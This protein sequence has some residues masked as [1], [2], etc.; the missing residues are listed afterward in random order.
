MT[1]IDFVN[2][3]YKFGA[4][5]LDTLYTLSKKETC[6]LCMWACCSDLDVSSMQLDL[7]DIARIEDAKEEAA[8]AKLY[9]DRFESL[10]WVTE[11]VL[12]NF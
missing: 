4:Y 1:S 11:Q 6:T 3:V 8:S 5:S 7:D 10:G 2:K 12:Y 9:E